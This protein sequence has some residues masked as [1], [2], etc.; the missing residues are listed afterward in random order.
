MVLNK[1]PHHRYLTSFKYPSCSEHASVTQRSVEN[2]PLCMFDRYLSIP[3]VLNM[4]GL[5]NTRAVNMPCYTWFFANC[6]LKIM[7]L[8]ST[9]AKV[10]N[11]SGVQISYSYK[12]V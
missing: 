1:I 5:E 2:I 3:L 7:V 4:L 9:Y 6:I 8:S 12:G 10:L 11:V